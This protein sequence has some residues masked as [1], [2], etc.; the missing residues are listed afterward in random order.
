MNRESFYETNDLAMAAALAALGIPFK[1]K[2]PFIKV[3]TARGEQYQFF[4]EKVSA[5][6]KFKTNDLM[7]AWNDDK[8]HDKNPEHPFAYIKCAFK[9]RDGLLDVVKKSVGMVMIEKNG[10]I[11]IISENASKELKDKIFSQI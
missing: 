10:K 8:F 3:R 6:G 7:R 4:F 11:A 2:E 9:N 5:C 1:D